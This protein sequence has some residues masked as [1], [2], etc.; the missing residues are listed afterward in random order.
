MYFDSLSI[1]TRI[2]AHAVI[3]QADT[4]DPFAWQVTNVFWDGEVSQKTVK[5]DHRAKAE[6]LW[7]ALNGSGLPLAR[8]VALYGPRS[9]WSPNI[10]LARPSYTH[11]QAHGISN[12]HTHL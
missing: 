9:P 3:T 2:S 8:K 10:I 5:K 12:S 1:A 6:V 4:R 11:S 7:Q